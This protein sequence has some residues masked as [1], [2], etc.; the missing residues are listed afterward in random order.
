MSPDGSIEERMDEIRLIFTSVKEFCNSGKSVSQIQDNLEQIPLEYRSVG[1]ES[2][3]MCL[4]LRD[5]DSPFSNDEFD[6]FYSDNL[7]KYRVQLLIGLG[8]AMA[9]KE[10]VSQSVVINCGRESHYLFDGIG[11]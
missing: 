10:F 11:Y 6:Q 2:A 4:S 3:S 9:S 5:E 7:R 8:W 1:F